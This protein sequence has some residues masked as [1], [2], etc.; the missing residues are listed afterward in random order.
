LAKFERA[1]EYE[2]HLKAETFPSLRKLPGFLAASIHRRGL[3][4]GVEFVVLSQWESR[5]AIARFAGSDLEA[6]VV[7]TNVQAMMVEFDAR[8][9]HYEVVNCG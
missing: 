8:A 4:N 2:E 3:E 1:N 5:E 9:R 7:P 6:A